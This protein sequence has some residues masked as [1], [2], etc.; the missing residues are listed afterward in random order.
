MTAQAGDVIPVGQTIALIFGADEAGAVQA[1][2]AGGARRRAARSGFRGGGA[3]RRRRGAEGI[4]PG[5]EGRRAARRRPRPGDGE[6]TARIEKA[7]V[8]AFVGAAGRRG[9]RAT[10]RPRA[11]PPASPK[12]RR[13]AAE[14]GLDVSALRGSGPGGAVLTAD[15]LAAAA[16]PAAP[17]PAPARVAAAAPAGAPRVGTIWRVM[18]E[19]MTQS[20][21]TAPQFYLVR[22]VDGDRLVAW[23]ERAV[24]Q[25]GARVTYTDLL[26]KLVAAAIGTASRRERVLAGRRDRARRPTSTSA[27]PWPSTTGWSFP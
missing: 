13:L 17:H 25:T 12:A 3:G 10:G 15:V 4:P 1:A 16:R 19:R 6:R 5:A 26:V 22:E 2:A 14:R 24:K 23:R 9:S 18:V 27:W 8:L 21:T 20:W 11:S 7:D